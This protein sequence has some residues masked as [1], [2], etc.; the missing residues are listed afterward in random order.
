MKKTGT[1]VNVVE[2]E[3]PDL[4]SAGEQGF[5]IVDTPLLSE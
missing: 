4:P 2:P 3:E 5:D 1:T